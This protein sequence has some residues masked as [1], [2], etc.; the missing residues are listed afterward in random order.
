MTGKE[1]VRNMT[2]G[3]EITRLEL[4]LNGKD[5]IYNLIN[6]MHP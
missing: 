1:N 3:I 6:L 2:E 5:I 4:D